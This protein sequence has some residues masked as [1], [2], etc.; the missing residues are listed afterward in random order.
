MGIAGDNSYF[1]YSFIHS[2]I[3]F[4]LGIFGNRYLQ[5]GLMWDDEIW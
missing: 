4:V 5:R 3:L 1:F 2:F